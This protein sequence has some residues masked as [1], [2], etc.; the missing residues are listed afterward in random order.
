MRT[1]LIALAACNGDKDKDTPTSTGETGTTGTTPSD[2]F[3][4]LGDDTNLPEAGLL[5]IWGTS[6]TDVWIVGADPGDG[7]GPMVL[8]YDGTA[9]TRHATGTTGD[10]WWVWSDGGDTIWMSGEGGRMLTYDRV[11]GTFVEDV[12]TNPAYKLFG[13]WGTG[14][15][16]IW[17]VASDINNA[18]DGAI[19]HYDGAAWTESTTIP[20]DPTNPVNRRQP[21]KVWGCGG[22]DVWTIGTR[23]VALHWNGTTWEDT[24]DQP[25][26]QS[27]TLVTV[28]GRACDDA[29]AVGGFGNAVTIHWDGSLWTDVSPPLTDIVPGMNGVF[30]SDAGSTAICGQRGSIYWR[31]GTAWVADARPPATSRDFH[32]CWIDE[33]GAVWA[34]GGDLGTLTEG[35]VVYGGIAAIPPI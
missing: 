29:Y 6:S 13:V 17:T 18:I 19:L 7:L 27:I 2:A 5:S 12:I 14:P 9:W 32:A 10:L 25:V 3:V 8:S 26:Y 34:V 15:S 21:F 31:E 11:G 20:P 1:I 35:V 23:A 24:W 30:A 4:V 22:S 16:D 28:H 33:A